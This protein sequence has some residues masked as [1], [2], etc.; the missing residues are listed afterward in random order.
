MGKRCLAL[1]CPYEQDVCRDRIRVRNGL[2]HGHRMEAET[3]KCRVC[4][5]GELDIKRENHRYAESGLP[6][7]TLLNIEVR[8]CKKCG[9]RIVS[10]PRLEELHQLLAFLVASQKLRLDGV[11]VRFLR[12]YLGLSGKD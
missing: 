11:E 1:P 6:N 12:K 8:H 7:V 5:E 4:N 2:V 9:A 3:V 10:I